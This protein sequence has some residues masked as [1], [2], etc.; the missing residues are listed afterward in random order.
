MEFQK[1]RVHGEKSE[2]SQNYGGGGL[3]VEQYHQYAKSKNENK[4]LIQ[5]VH[6]LCLQ[7]LWNLT[8][9]TGH[10]HYFCSFSYNLHRLC[11]M[12]VCLNHS[13]KRLGHVEMQEHIG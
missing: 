9:P 12:S 5:V 8:H 13:N 10:F 1:G 4:S 11:G 3:G 7:T 2:L 6:K